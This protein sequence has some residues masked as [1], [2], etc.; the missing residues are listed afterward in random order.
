MV[1]NDK[2]FLLSGS[3]GTDQIQACARYAQDNNIPYVSAGVTEALVS[4]F[5]TYFTTSMTYPDQA[6]LLVDYMIQK[7]GA[8]S[9]KN[10]I[11]I[12]DTASF[13]DAHL[14]FKSAASKAGLPIA[15]DKLVS[16]NAGTGDARQ[17]IQDLQLK[18]IQ[19]VFVLTSPVFWINLSKAANAQAYKAQWVGVGISM[20]FDTVA[21][22]ACADGSAVD[23]AQFFSPFPAWQDRNRFDA[24]FDKAYNQFHSGGKSSDDFVWLAWMGTKVIWKM[25]EGVGEQ[26]TRERFIYEV[27][28]MKN[29]S[30]GFGPVLNYSPTDHF[31]AD[32]TYVSRAS[33]SSR[34]WKTI[35]SPPTNN[36]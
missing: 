14:A 7:L 12:F 11:V 15:Y 3:A 34:N 27:E 6:P 28:R 9:E 21:A 36:F 30:I 10:G 17:I 4:Q 16:K 33:C 32:T 5:R 29:L 35:V 1:E 22:A 24:E 23:G 31:G 25:F 20:T 26:L 13:K 2:V 8:K 19:N 18:G